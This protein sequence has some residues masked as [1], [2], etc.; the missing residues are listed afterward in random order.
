MKIVNKVFTV[1]AT[2]L[3]MV[4][5]SEEDPQLKNAPKFIAFSGS[6]SVTAFET[7]GTLEWTVYTTDAKGAEASISVS[8]EDAVEGVDFNISTTSVMIGQDEYE[9]TVE[10]ELIDNFEEEGNKTVT[11]TL[12]SD[13]LL[14]A[15]SEITLTI[16]ED[17]CAFDRS[18]IDGVLSGY[19]GNWDLASESPY[20]SVAEFNYI[21]DTEI[22]VVDLGV[23]W[24]N[25]WWG[26][27]VTTYYP[28][29]LTINE[30]GAITMSEG[31]V[32]ETTYNGAPQEAYTVAGSGQIST[33]DGT[34]TLLYELCNYGS[35]WNS[36]Y[37]QYNLDGG[38]MFKA[39]L[40]LPSAAE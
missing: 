37:A 2:L 23:P 26:E 32:M 15:T 12:E 7:A 4:G 21:S 17:D 29:T 38:T 22:E 14:G 35:C 3:L 40:N 11:F 8:S 16:V 1:T 10:V 9:T 33:C 27:V 24:M 36:T 6:S 20:P 25:D 28:I 39:V 5:C 31:T 34:L 13:L 30:A 18:L 19:D